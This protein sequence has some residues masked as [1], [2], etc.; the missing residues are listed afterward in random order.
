MANTVNVQKIHDGRHNAIFKVYLESDGAS[1]DLVD[2]I[3]V[4]AS[5]LLGSPNKLHFTRLLGNIIGFTARLEWDATAD[6]PILNLGDN[7]Y[8]DFD[9]RDEG[10]IPNDAGAGSTG[11]ILIT[12]NGFT[13]AQDRGWFLL[14]CTKDTLMAE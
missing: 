9:M 14:E 2:T 10:G 13:V 12:T 3:L 5:T 8:F 11:D 7:G 4:D 1:G 6:I